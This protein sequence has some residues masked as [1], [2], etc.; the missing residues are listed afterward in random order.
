VA[1]ARQTTPASA[2]QKFLRGAVTDASFSSG[3]N[4][5]ELADAFPADAFEGGSVRTFLAA[6]SWFWYCYTCFQQSEGGETGG[7]FRRGN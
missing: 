3:R 4:A 1:R 6:S 7:P 5:R 2:Q